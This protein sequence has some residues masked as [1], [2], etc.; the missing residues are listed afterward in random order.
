MVR[1]IAFRVAAVAALLVLAGCAWPWPALGSRPA[2]APSWSAVHADAANSDRS[3]VEPADDVSVRWQIQ[4]PGTVKLGPLPWTINLGPTSDAAGRLY[5]TSSE[6]RCHLQA[7]DGA[8]GRRRWC[9]DHL[10]LQAMVSSPLIDRH[11]DLYLADGH[12]MHAFT[13]SGTERWSTPLEGVPLSSQFTPDGRLLF[14]TH[15]GVVYVLD[16]RTGREVIAHRELAGDPT[17]TPA[18]GMA[19]CA[20]GTA[21]C[22]SA[23]TIAV[24][25]RTGTFF[26]T[27]WAPGADR[28]GIRAMRYRGG[29]HPSVR[30]VWSSDELPG[31][32]ASSPTLS[33][34]GRRVYV[35]DND[36]GLH[37]IDARTGATIWTYPLGF[38]AGGSP[39][40]SPDGLLMPA[41]GGQGAVQAIRDD[42]DHATLAWRRDDLVN[43]GIATQTAG[44]KAYV[45]VAAGVG[46][47]LVVVDTRDGSTLDDQA[48]PGSCVFSVGTTV[49]VD[50]TVYVPTI[51]GNL[52][53]YR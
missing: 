24:D 53:A 6:D 45:T 49:G 47:R 37:A 12:G 30:D 15:V 18:D 31:G 33:A 3:P 22:P 32:S 36:G 28:A 38:A 13:P 29:A 4:I 44:H 35:T 9:A 26:F 23:N 1:S 46:C 25:E 52:V 43:R 34:D 19:A 48:I 7:L 5:V 41:G 10:D 27:F 8:T 39:S 16:R 40:L 14:V 11:G 42:G 17:W 51:V 20:R 2:Y 21:D 50:G